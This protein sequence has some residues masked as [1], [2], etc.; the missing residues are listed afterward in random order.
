[1]DFSNPEAYIPL[2]IESGK[3]ITDACIGSVGAFSYPMYEDDFLMPVLIMIMEDGTLEWTTLNPEY[4][5]ESP[6]PGYAYYVNSFGQIAWLK[7]IV[8]LNTVSSAGEG[9]G[10]PTMYAT[11]VNGLYYDV[12][13]LFAYTIVDIRN[14]NWYCSLGSAKGGVEQEKGYLTLADNGTASYKICSG[15]NVMAEY[16]GS[17]E[18]V[19]A[20]EQQYAAGMMFLDLALTVS[21]DPHFTGKKTIKGS[22]F[23]EP[24]VHDFFMTLWPGDGDA[25]YTDTD[26]PQI[27][28]EFQEDY[29]FDD[30]P[31]FSEADLWATW[32]AFDVMYDK[33]TELTLYLEFCPNGWMEYAYGYAD[34]DIVERF[35][36]AYYVYQAADGDEYDPGTVLFDLRL[37]EG[38][39]LENVDP[40]NFF[41]AYKITKVNGSSITVTHLNGNPLF[42]GNNGATITFTES[43]G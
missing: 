34:S 17:Y 38:L 24:G 2:N 35:N 7:D 42:Y 15:K 23:C 27:K 18:M 4:L 30:D 26:G 29:G 6:I 10:E 12:A 40:Y 20:E 8:S 21:S 31:S 25:L 3:K 22:F 43:M 39:A 32:A 14:I 11:D 16:L 36:G 33:D 5:F 9:I 37:K 1:M 28:Y 13:K 19:F 41:G